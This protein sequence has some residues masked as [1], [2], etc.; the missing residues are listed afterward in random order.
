MMSLQF[1][2]DIILPAAT[3]SLTEINAKNICWAVKI[4]G[5]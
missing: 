1:F 2:M 5:V 4:A 3:L